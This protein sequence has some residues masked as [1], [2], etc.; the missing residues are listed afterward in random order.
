M[1][2]TITV[3]E[4]I[5]YPIKSLGAIRLDA[6]I[7][8]DKGF[9]YDR[10]Y[11]LVDDYGQFLTQ[12]ELPIMGLLQPTFHHDHW[13]VTA[14]AEKKNRVTFPLEPPHPTTPLT[15]N[16]WDDFCEALPYHKSVNEWFSEQLGTPC[17]LV[18]LPETHHRPISTGKF[19]VAGSLSF[20]DGYPYLITTAASLNDLNDKL[21]YPVSSL[22]FRP[23]IVLSGDL[24][25]FE[26]DHWT[27]F[28]IGTAQFRGLGPHA[29]CQVVDL[30][31]DTAVTDGIV[32]P[33]LAQ[34]RREN[35]KLNFGLSSQC[36]NAHEQPLIR[37][38]D[39]VILHNL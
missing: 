8:L 4:I 18:F 20:A 22:R 26:E 2:P 12:R 10:R 7:A 11:L 33:V 25:P 27:T 29:R 38:G 34:F 3:S 21:P 9:R 15:V 17:T 28:S 32:L 14:G 24:Q 36:T 6:N 30:N 23:N 1:T 39:K 37:I 19:Q 13:E 5:I 31:P 35:R 16:V